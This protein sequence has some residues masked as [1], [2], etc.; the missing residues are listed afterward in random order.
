MTGWRDR[1]QHAFAVNS[2]DAAPTSGQLIL[3]DRLASELDRRGMTTPAIAFLEMSRPM[4][5]ISAQALHML[6]PVV[7]ALT[8]ARGYEEFIKFLERRDA[9][10]MLIE[11]LERPKKES[12]R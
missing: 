5:Y 8:D 3:L 10:D 6:T 7:S 4:N 2:D 11:R 12:N 9:I 1:L